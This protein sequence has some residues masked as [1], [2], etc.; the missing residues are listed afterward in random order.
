[1]SFFT[2]DLFLVF[3]VFFFGGAQS[4]PRNA[5]NQ[6]AVRISRPLFK[7]ASWVDRTPL[8]IK[9]NCISYFCS[10]FSVLIHLFNHPLTE[11]DLSSCSV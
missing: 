11:T 3:F 2:S 7:G 6:D 5:W 8:P 9:F 4:E 10:F 1:M